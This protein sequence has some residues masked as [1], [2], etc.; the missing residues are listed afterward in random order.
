MGRAIRYVG[1]DVHADTIAVAVTKRRGEVQFMG[2]INNNPSA[3]RRLIKKLGDP[4]TLRVCYEAGPT[5]Y[6]LYWQLIR[7]GVDCKVV[8]PMLINTMPVIASTVK[9]VPVSQRP[10]IHNSG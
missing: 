4:K 6:P 7:T 3:V 9:G 1:L 2:T 8:A 10:F 5:G